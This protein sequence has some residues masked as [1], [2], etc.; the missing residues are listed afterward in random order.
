MNQASRLMARVGDTMAT[1]LIAIA[2]ALLPALL[3]LAA[4][5]GGGEGDADG[6]D[7][8]AGG[9]AL[10]C[11]FESDDYLPYAP[12]FTWTYRLTD[13][14]DGERAIKEQRI[15]PE[16]DHPD[17]GPVVVQVTGK[18]SGETVSLTRREGDR[19]LRFEQE[20]RDASGA[21]ER[22]TVYQPP[23]VRIDESSEHVELGAAWD[24]TYT[25]IEYDPLGVEVMRVETVDHVE[26]LGVDDPCDSPMGEFSCLRVRR[27]RL[28]GGVAEKEFHFARGIGK[29][30][31]VG[32]NQLEELTAC[33]PLGE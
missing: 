4:C 33:G 16:V 1:R 6:G 3:P 19:V 18:Q 28:A 7:V 32:S 9:D 13:L 31:E 12:G 14:D 10:D 22:T 25:E 2:T 27:T 23:Q 17:Y 5:G 20:D 30:R 21:L 8:D 26:I 29:I 11:S 24:E 15:D